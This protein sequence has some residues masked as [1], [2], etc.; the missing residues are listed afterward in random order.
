MRP[1]IDISK[2][3]APQRIDYAVLSQSIEG[4]ILRACY[5]NGKDV[6]F[7]THYGEFITFDKPLGAYMFLTNYMNVESQV[8]TLVK[9]TKDK[10]LPLGVW[11]D[12][13]LE[14]GAE[15]LTKGVVLKAVS[16][17]DAA[18]GK[19]VGIYTSRYYWEL[20]MGKSGLKGHPLWVA[21]YGVNVPALPAGWDNYVLHQYTSTGRLPG[22]ASSLDLDRFNGD[23]KQFQEWIKQGA[24]ELPPPEPL[25]DGEALFRI[26][27]I[28]SVLNVRSGPDINCSQKGLTYKGETHEVYETKYGWFRI[29][30]GLWVS[31]NPAYVKR[32]EPLKPSLEERVSALETRVAKLEQQLI[33]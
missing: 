4:A 15:A 22:Y 17:I 14:V 7:E 19:P 1:L 26:E 12:V 29:G 10:N 6:S 30:N 8:D 5:G 16:Q 28:C 32:L 33:D 3:Q 24:G 20:I 2:H 18:I 27:V 9:A 23:D 21:H 13:E 25:P 11:L 31:G